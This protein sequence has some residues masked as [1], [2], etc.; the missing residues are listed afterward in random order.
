[1][2][3]IRVMLFLQDAHR[4]RVQAFYVG[5]TETISVLRNFLIIVYGNWN[6]A[7]TMQLL[8]QGKSK[9]CS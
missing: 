2:D 5:S 7:Q 1:M 6:D 4:K 9:S 8:Q 3:K